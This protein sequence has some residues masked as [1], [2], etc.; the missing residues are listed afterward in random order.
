MDIIPT[1]SSTKP[2]SFVF[3]NRD[4]KQHFFY[5]Q[6]KLPPHPTVEDL[7]RCGDFGSKADVLTDIE[8]GVGPLF[9]CN[10]DEASFYAS[11]SY[12]PPLDL[13]EHMMDPDEDVLEY[14]SGPDGDE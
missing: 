3:V 10:R 7:V 5:I 8:Q 4:Q 14:T 9:T 1:A 12:E 6:Q 11:M 13:S 2:K